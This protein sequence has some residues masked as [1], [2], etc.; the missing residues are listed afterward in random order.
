MF[1]FSK[2]AH[3]MCIYYQA[4]SQNVLI[5]DSMD[6]MIYK[7]SLDPT[8]KKILNILYPFKKEIH[9]IEPKT[10]QDQSPSCAIFAIMYATMLLLNKDPAK[11]EIKL[12]H[13]HGDDTLHMRL[14][15]LK[16]FAERKLTLM[17][18]MKKN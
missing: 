17:D 10:Y 8:Q 13:I 2:R 18:E 12:N 1:G 4:S 16:M 7:N 9:F 14:H 15:I 6:P 3:A 5:Y 11:I